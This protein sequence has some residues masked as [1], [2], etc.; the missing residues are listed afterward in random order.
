MAIRH[1]Q[2]LLIAFA[3]AMLFSNVLAASQAPP[4]GPPIYV[5]ERNG[6]KVYI[7]GIALP[8]G[9]KWLTPTIKP[10]LMESEEL[11]QEDPTEQGFNQS[12]WEE[13]G[14][15]KQGTL[16]E[17]LSPE[18]ASCVRRTA[19]IYGVKEEELARQRPWF[20]AMTLVRAWC[21]KSGCMLGQTGT[22]ARYRWESHL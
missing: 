20:S 9:S 11:R 17:D 21:A 14:Y 22:P 3:M 6:A 16:F 4:S 2:I 13:L 7:L 15:R 1:C 10:A 19:H 12:L 5:A 18:I 8:P